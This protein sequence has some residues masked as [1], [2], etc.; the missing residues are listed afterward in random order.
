MITNL[1]KISWQTRFDALTASAVAAFDEAAVT[2]AKKLVSF[3]DER[4]QKLQGTAAAAGEA[5]KM[6]LLLGDAE[7]LPWVNGAVYLGRDA[8]MPSILLPTVIKPGIPPELFERALNE[9]FSQ[10]APFAVLPEKIIP[11]GAA[12]TLSRHVI[13]KWLSENR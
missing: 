3:D 5:G 7:H 12:K 6:I 2:L 11:F 10:L 8:Q 1:L 13:E 4:L 9:S